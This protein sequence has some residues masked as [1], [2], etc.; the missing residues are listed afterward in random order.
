MAPALQ[1]D[2]SPPDLRRSPSFYSQA[3]EPTWICG[4]WQL[5]SLIYFHYSRAKRETANLDAESGECKG[6]QAAL[7]Y[8][9]SVLETDDYPEEL[10]C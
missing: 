9:S 2:S 4:F 6:Q 3:K 7:P 1:E 5:P 8:F 10:C